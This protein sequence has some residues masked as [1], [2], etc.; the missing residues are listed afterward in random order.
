MNVLK[1]CP[2]CR[3]DLKVTQIE[4]KRAVIV[5]LHCSCGFSKRVKFRT[6][7]PVKLTTLRRFAYARH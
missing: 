3:R 1:K 6:V 4:N 5:H 7:K 2:V